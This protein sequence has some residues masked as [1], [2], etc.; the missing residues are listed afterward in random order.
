MT[1][2]VVDKRNNFNY[3]VTST[4]TPIVEQQVVY[5]Q[6]D[7]PTTTVVPTLTAK[8]TIQN[9]YETQAVT[10][11]VVTTY[12]NDFKLSDAVRFDS[13]KG[14]TVRINT[15]SANA[16]QISGSIKST[17]LTTDSASA[18]N[19]EIRSTGSLTLGSNAPAM[20]NPLQSNLLANS[21]NIQGA[22]LTVTK[23]VMIT[24]SNGKQVQSLSLNAG[25]GTLTLLSS[26]HPAERLVLKGQ[27]LIL[28]ASTT[29]KL[30]ANDIDIASGLTFKANQS[31]L[32]GKLELA[33]NS[34]G[35]GAASGVRLNGDD[36]SSIQTFDSPLSAWTTATPGSSAPL[37]LYNPTGS[38]T[39]VALGS[40]ANGAKASGQDVWTNLNFNHQGGTISFDL[41]RVDSWD[42]ERFYVFANDVAILDTVL[43]WELNEVTARSGNANGYSWTITPLNDYSSGPSPTPFYGNS[44]TFRVNINVSTSVTALKL[45]FGSSL[46]ES[47]DNESYAIDNVKAI[48]TLGQVL[49]DETFD[50]TLG[51]WQRPSSEHGSPIVRQ[52]SSVSSDY[53]MG[54]F[55]NG[56]KDS[57]GRDIWRDLSLS[58]DGASISFDFLRLDTWDGETFKIYANNEVIASIPFLYSRNEST[59][60]SGTTASGYR[61]AM[62][63][64]T[65][66]DLNGNALVDQKFKVVIDVPVA[67]TTLRIGF[68]S[69]LD[70][71]AADESWAIDNFRVNDTLYV[72]V[73]PTATA[74]RAAIPIEII[75][76]GNV[77]L[78]NS[79]TNDLN[80]SN[81]LAISVQ[82]RGSISK[83]LA[84]KNRGSTPSTT[85]RGAIYNAAIAMTSAAWRLLQR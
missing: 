58:G 38:T 79:T 6:R 68:G 32:N 33:I 61:Y 50:S 10:T 18:S 28:P 4:T 11:G 8:S 80:S 15:T 30:Y 41:K 47:V 83:G 43:A 64:L 20:V 69:T 72:S 3:S 82:T 71:N 44:Q 31:L 60:I 75:A 53:V 26:P 49:M 1:W 84:F 76:T 29:T 37:Y 55:A 70:Q 57:L 27:N 78:P 66:L 19:L 2:N 36:A 65:T 39:N 16:S 73:L 13:I 34:D 25:N 67:V 24:G 21:F 54:G 7:V 22:G 12:S 14:K 46:N 23:N 63:P 45:G 48:T 17:A 59:P 9:V 62:V 52:G 74:T 40:F 56:S 5:S 85:I 35:S 42:H 81:D 51:G 77:M